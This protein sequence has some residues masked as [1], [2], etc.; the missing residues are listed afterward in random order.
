MITIIAGTTKVQFAAPKL[1][2]VQ[3]VSPLSSES[4]LMN[5]KTPIPT[6]AKALTAIPTSNM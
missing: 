5:V 1:P 6:E 4:V 3:N 2:I